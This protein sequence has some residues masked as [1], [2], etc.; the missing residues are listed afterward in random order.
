MILGAFL[1]RASIFFSPKPNSEFPASSSVRLSKPIDSK[2]LINS[3]S[4]ELPVSIKML[5]KVKPV[6]FAV[7]TKASECR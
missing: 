3:M 7:A 6:T 5:C 4:V 2:A 1:L